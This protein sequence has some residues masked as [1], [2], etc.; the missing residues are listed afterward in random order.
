MANPK[1][2]YGESRNNKTHDSSNIEAL[3]VASASPTATTNVINGISFNKASA[4]NFIVSLIS[5]LWY[6]VPLMLMCIGEIFD[7]NNEKNVYE[8]SDYWDDND[9]ERYETYMSYFV[10]FLIASLLFVIA[11]V[12]QI[13]MW[14]AKSFV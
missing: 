11:T 2:E 9:E 12:I 14:F 4:F 5:Y 7:R 6:I 8:S 10:P 3:Q 13:Y 1:N